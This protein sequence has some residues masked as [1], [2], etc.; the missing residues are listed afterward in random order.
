M[1][2]YFR[3]AIKAAVLQWGLL[4]NRQNVTIQTIDG[5]FAGTGS[6]S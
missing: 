6:H 4:K 5:T 2:I 1:S 3:A